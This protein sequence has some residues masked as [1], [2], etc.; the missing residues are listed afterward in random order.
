MPV[1]MMDTWYLSENQRKHIKANNM[2][3]SIKPGATKT[4]RE[5]LCRDFATDM[6]K[7][8]QA[9][10][11]DVHKATRGNLTRLK[12]AMPNIKQ[13]IA[14]I[15]CYSGDHSF[16]KLHSRVCNGTGES[17]WIHKSVFLKTRL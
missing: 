6:S 5:K 3:V 10:F 9:E 2:A 1:H 11:D 8:C 12:S 13:A 7:R 15:S 16:C 4:Q 17:N 14:I